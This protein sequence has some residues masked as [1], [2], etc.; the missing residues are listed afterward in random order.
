MLKLSRNVSFFFGI[1][2]Y[3]HLYFYVYSYP[4]ENV[5]WSHYAFN[6]FTMETKN[7]EKYRFWLHVYISK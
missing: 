2:Y 7:N 3:E 4:D 1:L 6:I 5:L